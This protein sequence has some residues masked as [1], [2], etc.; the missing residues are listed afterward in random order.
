[1]L[2]V[3]YLQRKVRERNLSRVSYAAAAING[4]DSWRL[5]FFR[6]SPRGSFSLEA[7]FA[8]ADIGPRL[9]RLARHSV[10]TNDRAKA[11]M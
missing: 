8:T 2:A 4:A 10:A 11:K 1:M 9:A 6:N 3:R 7:Q 5:R